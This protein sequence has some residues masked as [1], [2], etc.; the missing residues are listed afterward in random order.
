MYWDCVSRRGWLGAALLVVFLAGCG[1][2]D[3]SPED[4]VRSTIA[5]LEQAVES[6]SIRD[7]AQYLHDDYTDTRHR[8]KRDAVATLFAY[9]HR[10]RSIHLFSITRSVLVTDDRTRADAVV[11]VAMGGVPIESLET[12]I[13]LQA[14][15]H[16]FELTF[17]ADDGEWLLISSEW[18]R[19][20]AGDL[21]AD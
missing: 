19:A 12:A 10:H 17:R 7:A 9:L 8:N 1:A 3:V 13:A 15:L 11:Y 4:A 2:D 21:V 16:R 5:A 18:R 20:S 14:D 6:E